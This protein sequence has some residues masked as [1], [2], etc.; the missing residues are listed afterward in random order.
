MAAARRDD[1]LLTLQSQVADALT[2]LK[3]ISANAG[4]SLKSAITNATACQSFN[5]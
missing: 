4:D 1:T 2:Q 3:T 5:S